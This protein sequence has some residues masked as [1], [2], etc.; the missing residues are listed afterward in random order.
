MQLPPPSEFRLC[1]SSDAPRRR[2]AIVSFGWNTPQGGQIADSMMR[3]SNACVMRLHEILIKRANDHVSAASSDDEVALTVFRST[4]FA[5]V[6]E[7]VITELAIASEMSMIGLGCKHGN[8]RGPWVSKVVCAILNAFKAAD[9]NV[10]HGPFRAMHFNA[11]GP[12]IR[13]LKIG[14][15]DPPGLSLCELRDI[16]AREATAAAAFDMGCKKIWDSQQPAHM[17]IAC[18]MERLKRSDEEQ[19]LLKSVIPLLSSRFDQQAQKACRDWMQMEY[20]AR[21]L[22]KKLVEALQPRVEN[23]NKMLW[24][25]VKDIVRPGVS[26]N[27]RPGKRKRGSW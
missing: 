9:A 14:H 4:G 11:F 5:E 23:M 24:V 2:V 1:G 27:A 20:N 17:K 6:V 26:D 8:H 16:A 22:T 21:E 15:P 10:H 7:F 3:M 12:A 18:F 13:W 19:Q 25:S